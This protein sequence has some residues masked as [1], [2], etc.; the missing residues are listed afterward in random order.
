LMWHC[1]FYHG[2]SL[3]NAAEASR[4][5]FVEYKPIRA[6]A[7]READ[8]VFMR[9]KADQKRREY[10]QKKVQSGKFDLFTEKPKVVNLASRAK[11]LAQVAARRKNVLER[12]QAMKEFFQ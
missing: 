10:V 7:L 6:R 1:H 12:R 2:L 4:I 3:T 11:F 5:A 9:E 8:K